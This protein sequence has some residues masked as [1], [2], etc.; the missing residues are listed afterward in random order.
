MVQVSEQ[1]QKRAKPLSAHF[2]VDT[3]SS[4]SVVNSQAWLDSYEEFEAPR[5]VR[6]GGKSTLKALGKGNACLTSFE[7]NRKAEFVLNDAYLVP[8]TSR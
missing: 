3:G 7:D 6:L 1:Q 8:H 2:V 5:E 4:K